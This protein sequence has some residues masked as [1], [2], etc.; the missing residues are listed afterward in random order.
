MYKDFDWYTELKIFMKFFI[1]SFLLL[2]VIQLISDKIDN[3]S[4]NYIKEVNTA[5]LIAIVI[6]IAKC[7]SQ[8]ASDNVRQ[9]MHYS[10]SAVFLSK[11]NV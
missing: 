7:I 11:Y 1:E 9:G 10:I 4:I 5:L 3:N 6:Y 8:D 2:I